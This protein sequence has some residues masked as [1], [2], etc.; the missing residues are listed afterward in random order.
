M[1]RTNV[2]VAVD[3]KLTSLAINRMDQTLGVVGGVMGVAGSLAGGAASGNPLGIASGIAGGIN[4]ALGTISDAIKAEFPTPQTT[5]ST[6]GNLASIMEPWKL[7]ATFHKIANEDREHFGRPLCER[8]QLSDGE[9]SGFTQCASA[10]IAIQGT[11][12][13]HDMI[14]NFLNSGFYK[15]N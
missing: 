4:A 1:Y 9:L 7:Q 6:S 13:E 8:V 15:E 5:G 14:I 10:T 3:F 12:Q 2:N 11:S